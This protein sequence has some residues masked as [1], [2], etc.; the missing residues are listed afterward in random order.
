MVGFELRATVLGHVV[1]GAPPTAFDRFLATRLGVGA[2]LS[3]SKGQSGVLVGYESGDVICTPLELVAV[4]KFDV[5]DVPRNSP[6]T[7]APGAVW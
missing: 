4:R 7:Q 2:T 6:A 3:L 1:R 5:A